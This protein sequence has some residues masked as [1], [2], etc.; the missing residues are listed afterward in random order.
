MHPY[1]LQ[2]ER[3][4]VG[5]YPFFF[6]MGLSIGFLVFAVL[7]KRHNVPFRRS[8]NCSFILAVMVVVGG[9]LLHA[10]LYSGRSGLSA[11]EVFRL[12]VAGEVLY[13][14]LAI[15]AVSGWLLARRW[16]LPVAAIFDAA[17]VGAPVG[18][19]VGRIG[20]LMQGCCH[21]KICEEWFGVSYPK[22]ID[23]EGRIVG[24]L[25]F[26]RHV[27][28]KAVPMGA[29]TSSPVH[30][31]QVY[32]SIACL[33]LALALYLLWKRGALP[34]RLFLVMVAAYCSWRFCAEFLRVHEHVWLGLTVFQL[35]SVAFGVT[36]AGLLVSRKGTI[37][38]V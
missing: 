19:A 27:E 9:R 1:L 13:G 37:L 29:S 16:Q 8:V 32:E 5:S 34:G 18:I 12:E 14:S 10:V 20:C 6:G 35:I 4:T 38:R 21:G 26:L 36:S 24:S 3:L 23:V 7:L 15:G 33:L 28:M 25:A 11:V 22:M 2:S 17:A 31:V 30:P